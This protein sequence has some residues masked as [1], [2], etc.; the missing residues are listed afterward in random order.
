MIQLV[1]NL[2]FFTIILGIPIFGSLRKVA[3]FGSFLQGSKHGIEKAISIAPYIIGM[4]I[5][6]GMLQ[7]SGFFVLI[8][9]LLSQYIPQSFPPELLSLALLRPVSGSGTIALLANV[10]DQFGPDSMV[11]RIA[12]TIFGSTETT[13]YVIAIYFSSIRV[14]HYRHALIVGLIADFTGIITSVIICNLLFS[15]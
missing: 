3:I 8:S 1:S 5:A 12:C 4:Y 13:L 2:I 6:V 7:A 15:N 14:K 9:N 11:S 10:I